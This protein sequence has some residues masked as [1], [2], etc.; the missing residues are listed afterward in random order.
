MSE[1]IISQLIEVASHGFA[2]IVEGKPGSGKVRLCIEAT[3]RMGLTPSYIPLDSC[4]E[5]DFTGRDTPFSGGV[6]HER[7]VFDQLPADAGVV[8]D[9]LQYVNPYLMPQIALAVIAYVRFPTKKRATF[10]MVPPDNEAVNGWL[11]ELFK[12]ATG[13]SIGGIRHTVRVETD[14]KA[15]AEEM[16]SHSQ[17]K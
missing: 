3:K 11:D 17:H 2:V 15:I 9:G 16:I 12:P 6:V 7:G 1:E 5:I 13:E 14:F 10:I 8:L 4:D